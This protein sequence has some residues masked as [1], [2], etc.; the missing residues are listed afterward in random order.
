VLDLLKG[1][2]GGDQVAVDFGRGQRV[3]EDI[4]VGKRMKNSAGEFLGRSVYHRRENLTNEKSNTIKC[5]Y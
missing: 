4:G 5:T 3:I 2:P 1:S